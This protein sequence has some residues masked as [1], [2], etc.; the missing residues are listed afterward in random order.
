[1]LIPVTGLADDLAS[2]RPRFFLN[3]GLGF[4]GLGLVLHGVTRRRNEEA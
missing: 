3:L 1:M 2:V 4:F